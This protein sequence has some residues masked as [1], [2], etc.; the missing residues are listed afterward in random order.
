MTQVTAR[1]ACAMRTAR[2]T[3][4]RTW[5]GI[6]AVITYSVTSENSDLQV[7]FLLVVG[8]ESSAGLLA[9]DSNHRNVIGFGVVKAGQQMDR[10]WT[11]GRV[12]EARLAGE[13]RVRGGHEGRHLL[14]AHL[15]IIHEALGFLERY[16]EA[17]NTIARIAVDARQSPLCEA[18]PNKLRD[19]LRHIRYSSKTKVPAEFLRTSR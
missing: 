11:R 15:N 17:A 18:I 7:D 13:L 6:V 2:S 5:P 3:N 12:T 9:Y 19:V 10:A 1:F 4:V 16:V 8:A 14:M